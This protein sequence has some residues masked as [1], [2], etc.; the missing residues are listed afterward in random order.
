M[1]EYLIYDKTLI[2]DMSYVNIEFLKQ[3]EVIQNTDK[4]ILSIKK[5]TNVED[6]LQK[7]LDN[8]GFNHFE[9]LYDK[10]DDTQSIIYLISKI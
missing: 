2:L 5:W 3:D 10:Q 4:F 8:T 1:P 9:V 6:I 7:I